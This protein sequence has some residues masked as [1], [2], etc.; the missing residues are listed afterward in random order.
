VCCT[1]WN[2]GRRNRVNSGTIR[3][4]S[5]AQGP[6]QTF[7]PG[8]YEVPLL[9]SSKQQ[10]TKQCFV[11][12]TCLPTPLHSNQSVS[13]HTLIHRQCVITVTGASKLTR[14]PSP[15][16]ARRCKTPALQPTLH[17]PHSLVAAESLN[18]LFFRFRESP[19]AAARSP[20]SL[21]FSVA[22]QLRAV[23]RL[24]LLPSD[25]QRWRL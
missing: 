12:T 7:G 9:P 13:Y 10:Y 19:F 23:L 20:R 18:I 15:I 1:V 5:A 22:P 11:P 21:H 3:F 14:Q 16:T 24:D 8:H 25:A 6:K 4:L 2:G 17:S